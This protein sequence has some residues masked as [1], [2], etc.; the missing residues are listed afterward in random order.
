ME[1]HSV[2]SSRSGGVFVVNLIS[3]KTSTFVF[4]STNSLCEFCV[5]RRLRT[6]DLGLKEFMDRPDR[7]TSRRTRGPLWRYV[8]PHV[9]VK[10]VV[11]GLLTVI[12]GRGMK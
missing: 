8:L 2:V 5:F 7:R 1:S 6:T 12:D 3:D 10:V 9:G 11:E 4:D